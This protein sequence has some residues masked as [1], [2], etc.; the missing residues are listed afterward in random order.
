MKITL[1][2]FALV[3]LCAVAHAGEPAPEETA[4]WR[5]LQGEYLEC[6]SF[7]SVVGICMESADNRD[8]SERARKIQ[9]MMLK[10]AVTLTA[11]AKLKFETIDAGTKLSTNLMLE[12]IGK[13]CG[14]ISIVL[15]KY[16][17]TCRRLFENP[18]LRELELITEEVAPSTRCVIEHTKPC[19]VVH[20]P[21]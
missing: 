20:A 9:D 13:D 15:A 7:Y 10:R 14:N 1:A 8:L 2:A 21:R 17:K 16:G 11:K 19:S 12:E 5:E 6:V 4:A 18:K 3:A